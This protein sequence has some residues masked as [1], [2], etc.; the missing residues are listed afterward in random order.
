ME[1]SSFRRKQI[2]S[3]RS[4][5]FGLISST[6][7]KS[8]RKVLTN[9]RKYGIVCKH[10]KKCH[11]EA[12]TFTTE[13]HD[14]FNFAEKSVVPHQP[15]GWLHG[16]TEQS[17]AEGLFHV[18]AWGSVHKSQVNHR[19]KIAKLQARKRTGWMPWR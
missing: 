16:R 14:Y 17:E 1:S 8:P 13:E 6:A 4:S 5:T 3:R 18:Q 15:A 19:N 10:P 7:K 2:L 9:I 12:R 11:Q